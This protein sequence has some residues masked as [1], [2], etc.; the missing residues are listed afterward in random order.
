LSSSSS[1]LECSSSFAA[2]HCNIPWQHR[3]LTSHVSY[4]IHPNLAFKESQHQHWK[5]I[6]NFALQWIWEVH[7]Q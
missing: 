7:M 2:S 3:K 5:Q 1:S 6:P 4:G